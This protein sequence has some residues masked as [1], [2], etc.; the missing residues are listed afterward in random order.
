[1]KYTIFT[2]FFLLITISVSAQEEDWMTYPVKTKDTIIVKGTI[3][4]TEDSRT[5]KLID[6]MA[7]PQPPEYKV[8][9]DGYRVQ[10][11]FS[12]DRDLINKQ[13]ENFQRSHPEV[14]TYVLYD[15]P[16]YSIKVGNFR[17]EIE[18]EEMRNQISIEFPSS[19]IQKSKIELPKIKEP[20]IAINEEEN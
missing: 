4:Y 14:E 8:M 18:A 13:R 6:F 3:S 17:T 16:N 5:Q 1:M 20:Q 2:A 9:I 7:A 10:I 15:A 19:I 11:Y 12:N